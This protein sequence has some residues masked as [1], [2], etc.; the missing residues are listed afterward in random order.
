MPIGHEPATGHN[1][2]RDLQFL[3]LEDS[4]L[5]VLQPSRSL[6]GFGKSIGNPID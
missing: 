3:K 1:D 2:Y 5:I 4:A 6:G